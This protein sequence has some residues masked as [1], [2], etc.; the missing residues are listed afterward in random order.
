MNLYNDDCI[1][2]LKRIPDN[3]VDLV[4]IDPPYLL[5]TDGAGM[6]GTK[7]VNNDHRYVMKNIDF[8]KNGIDESVLD[9]LYRVMKKVNIYIWCSQKQLPIFYKYFVEKHKCNWNLLC[10]HKTNPTPA[11]G[12]KYLTDTEFILFFRDK[13]VKIYGEYAT[14]RTFYV[15]TKNLEDKKI[16]KHP[17]IK[18]LN[19]VEN[20]VINSSQPGDVVLDCYMGSGTTG[21]ACKELNRKFIGV[22]LNKEYFDIAK[23]RIEQTNEQISLF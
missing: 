13:G 21:V 9:E 23:Q 22:E 20:L 2:V 18:P 12:N 5:E 19:I 11:C 16:W 17:T 10:W 8:M 3:T 14:K 4:I 7:A 6:F 1:N 15:S